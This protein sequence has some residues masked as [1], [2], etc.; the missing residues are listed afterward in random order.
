[1]NNLT[2][3]IAAL[4]LAVA[5]MFGVA[6]AVSQPPTPQL[7]IPCEV[8]NIVDGD[9]VDVRITIDA[10]IRLLDCWAAE[11]NTDEGRAATESLQKHLD[12]YGKRGVLIVPLDRGP[13]GRRSRLDDYLTFGRILGHVQL[14]GSPETVSAY[15]VRGGHATERKP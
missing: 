10:R 6:A 13:E 8:I 3:R 1:M 11:R 7:T 4:S 5:A 12:E 15:Q 9:T 14:A 2:L